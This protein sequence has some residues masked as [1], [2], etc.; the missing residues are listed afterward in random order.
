MFLI[1]EINEMTM[2]VG[3]AGGIWTNAKSGLGKENN[4][5]HIKHRNWNKALKMRYMMLGKNFLKFE[6]NCGIGWKWNE[7]CDVMDGN[8]CDP[9]NAMTWT[10]YSVFSKESV[11]YCILGLLP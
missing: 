10:V 8:G 1:L 6:D 7:L 11:W 4:I 5:I 2:S 9:M 3:M